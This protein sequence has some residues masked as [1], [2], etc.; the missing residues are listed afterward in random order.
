MV[1]AAV[2]SGFYTFC[3]THTRLSFITKITGHLG[4]GIFSLGLGLE[5]LWL[6]H[7]PWP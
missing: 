6:W 1:V 5:Y 4:L 2:N 7:W 3:A